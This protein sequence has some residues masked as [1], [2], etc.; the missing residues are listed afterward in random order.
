MA[1]NWLDWVA[2]VLVIIGAI[3]IGLAELGYNVLDMVIG[4][5][6][7]L[8]MAVNILI[9]LSGLYLIYYVAKK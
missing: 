4:S 2:I 6:S 3:N 1:K 8:S 7:Q 5:I 9:G